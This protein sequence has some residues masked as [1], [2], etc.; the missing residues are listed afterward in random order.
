MT[1]RV[2]IERIETLSRGWADNQLYSVDYERRDGRREHLHRE[3]HDHGHGA[4]VLP[5]DSQRQTVLLVR[6]FRLPA[7]LCG[8]GED[9][10]EA[11]AGLLDGNPPAECA[12]REAR[13]ELGFDL[14][15]IREVASTFMTPGAVTER[16]TM[17]LADYREADRIGLGGGEAHEGE[18]IEVI[19]LPCSEALAMAV[20]GRI[21]DAKTVMLLLFLDRELKEKTVPRR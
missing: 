15:N 21:I 19:E 11:C 12:R 6:Q 18:D 2:R 16:I 7:Y 13:E 9:L 17:F 10:L 3:V 5:Y 1:Q 4:A 14:K 20:E 8:A